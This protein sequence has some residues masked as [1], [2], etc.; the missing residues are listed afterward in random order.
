VSDGTE[1]PAVRRAAWGEAGLVEGT[2]AVLWEAE[3]EADARDK[4]LPAASLGFTAVLSWVR[5][6]V[7][8]FETASPE[9]LP[10]LLLVSTV[11]VGG[12]ARFVARKSYQVGN[13]AVCEPP[14]EMYL[15]ER[16]DL[17]RVAVSAPV[18][19]WAASRTC[20]AFSLDCSPGGVRSYLPWPVEV[21]EEAL[22]ELDLGQNGQLRAVATVR[23]CVGSEGDLWLAGFQFT[24]LPP[25]GRRQ[26]GHFL[27]V[28]ERRL[29]PRVR[30]LTLV[31]Y[32]SHARKGFAEAL[33][34][35]L[36]PGALTLVVYEP[37]LPGDAVEV[38]VR[39][40]KNDFAFTGRVVA[41]SPVAEPGETPVRYNV[42]VCLDWAGG[43]AEE[44]FR[45][46]VRELA[47]EK[48]ASQG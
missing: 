12:P 24:S 7:L 23:H 33:V 26:L 38:H 17:F 32:R 18:S 28:Q 5:A 6:K 43:P 3:S 2:E 36:S 4:P 15:V 40:K 10:E 31:E 35:E 37:H 34:S 25:T 20:S 11:A 22:V 8:R 27:A 1:P 42:R 21:G 14:G 44:Q 29:M 41:C 39:L 16:R 48:L 19:V 30:A 45:A 9:P 46:A 13:T 47:V